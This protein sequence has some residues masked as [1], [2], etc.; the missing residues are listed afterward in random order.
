MTANFFHKDFIDL[1]EPKSTDTEFTEYA[2]EKPPIDIDR[3]FSQCFLDL[4][5]MMLEDGLESPL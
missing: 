5:S 2:Q 4:R 3:P 1:L